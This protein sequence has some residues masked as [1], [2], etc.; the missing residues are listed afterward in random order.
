MQHHN[1]SLL[2]LLLLFLSRSRGDH[3][4]VERGEPISSASSSDKSVTIQMPGAKPTGTDSYF[5]TSFNL[6]A[7]APDDPTMF[8][9]KFEPVAAEG[10]KHLQNSGAFFS[11]IFHE[12][13]RK[14][15]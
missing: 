10:R 9:T 12:S 15:I 2:T 14:K 4:R 3:S 11:R 1:L 8:V 13:S 5:C 6:A 7:L